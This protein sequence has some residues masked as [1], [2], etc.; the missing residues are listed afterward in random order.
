MAHGDAREGKWR[1]KW[2]MEWVANTLHTTLEHGV[3][4]ITT[5]N[6][7]ASAV[8]SRLNWRPRS[9][10][11]DSSVSPTDEI[12]FLRV[13]H[14]ISTGLYLPFAARYPFL[15]FLF[16]VFASMPRKFCELNA[17]R[18]HL[19]FWFWE[20]FPMSSCARQALC[21]DTFR[22]CCIFCFADVGC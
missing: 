1:G 17:V 18:A 22:G 7:H 11:M 9:I 4:S 6:V 19:F 10:Y 13:C 20:L 3:S 16:L 14:H 5:A 12:W 15:V 21:H 2:R 8:S